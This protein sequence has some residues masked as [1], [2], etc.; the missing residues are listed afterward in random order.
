ME[1][2]RCLSRQMHDGCKSRIGIAVHGK[3]TSVDRVSHRAL[4]CK[5]LPS[6]IP[7]SK[8]SAQIQWTTHGGRVHYQWWLG[9]KDWADTQAC[10][11]SATL[12]DR[13]NGGKPRSASQLFTHCRAYSGP[14][15][16][17]SRYAM[18]AMPMHP[19]DP[20][21]NKF[22]S[23]TSKSL[24]MR[25]MWTSFNGNSPL[26]GTLFGEQIPILLVHS[27]KRTCTW[28]DRCSWNTQL[29]AYQGTTISYHKSLRKPIQ[30]LHHSRDLR[31][32][33]IA[34]LSRNLSLKSDMPPPTRLMSCVAP[35]SSGMLCRHMY[36]T[37][38]KSQGSSV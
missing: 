8:S 19:P 15:T 20:Q 21:N 25:A 32:C 30:D 10:N 18:L 31:A 17:C 4:D 11:R 29:F 27:D 2:E 5:G 7:R 36:S 14:T 35:A 34:H 3:K 22:Y 33:S 13:S 6:R 26:R 12:C 16:T 24:L 1:M 37:R 28:E 9:S 23:M 38:Q